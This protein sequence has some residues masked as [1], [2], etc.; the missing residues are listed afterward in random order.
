[1]QNTDN[2]RLVEI[3]IDYT[4]TELPE[5]K[6]EELV[7]RLA[8]KTSIQDVSL[9]RSIGIPIFSLLMKLTGKTFYKIHSECIEQ[10]IWFPDI[11][12]CILELEMNNNIAHPSHYG[13]KDNP[14]EAIKVI[15]AWNLSF[16]LGNTVKY[17]S[18][19]GKKDAEKHIEDLEKA[20]VYIDFE[21]E[22]LKKEQ[23]ES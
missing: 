8:T 5:Q 2:K 16:E 3:I 14:Y 18:R 9:L 15:R 19:A 20:K 12:K 6:I 23:S 21:I 7:E 22:R 10:Q 17:I 13:G 1:M 4:K 11:K